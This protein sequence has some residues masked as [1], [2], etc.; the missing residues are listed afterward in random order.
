MG[1]KLT[2]K[3]P[4]FQLVALYFEG[5]LA[6]A[7]EHV[8]LGLNASCCRRRHCPTKHIVQVIEKP[9]LLSMSVII[10]FQSL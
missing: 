1:V 7:L 3:D 2:R 4:V 9:F 8:S 6:C 5:I 10:A